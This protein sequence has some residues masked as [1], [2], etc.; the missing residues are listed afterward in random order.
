MEIMDELFDLPL[1]LWV[2]LFY[3]ILLIIGV[4]FFSIIMIYLLFYGNFSQQMFSG[5]Y[6]IIGSIFLLIPNKKRYFRI[7]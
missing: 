1:F 3:Y 7:I 2:L 6:F 4:I 5:I